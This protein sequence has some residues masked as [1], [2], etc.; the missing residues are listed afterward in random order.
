MFGSIAIE[1]SGYCNR[2]CP[3][4]PVSLQP[5]SRGTQLP[6]ELFASLLA[7]LGRIAYSGRIALH[8]YN[9]PLL[10][11]RIVEKV[12][13]AVAAVPRARVEMNSNGDYASASLLHELTDAGLSHI[14]VT[15]YSDSAF[16]RLQALHRQLR[17]DA[18]RI[19]AIRRAPAF[20]SNRG[21]S[22]AHLGLPQ[23]LKADC[24]LPRSQL[25]INYQGDVLLCCDDYFAKAVMGNIR[26]RDILEI[27]RG[28][29]FKR[30]RRL[31]KK[32]RRDALGPCRECNLLSSPFG[33]RTL[34][35][36][37]ALEYNARIQQRRPIAARSA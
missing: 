31:L 15:G 10:D 36:A 21:G 29:S 3:S 2:R 17:P 11:S 6:D 20:T 33:G 35:P 12:R 28:P 19:V 32:R 30:A 18:Q 4:C 25:A 34:T 5:R 26:D 16:R 37:Q 22:L 8:L 7:Q 24:F 9:E 13:R 23:T 14:L 27:W 1:T